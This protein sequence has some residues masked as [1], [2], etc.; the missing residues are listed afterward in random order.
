MKVSGN[1]ENTNEPI[2]PA[3]VLFGLILV[4]FLPPINLPIINPPVSEKMQIDISQI[5]VINDR[6]YIS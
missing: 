6:S 1:K 5:I 2:L 3:I 4:N